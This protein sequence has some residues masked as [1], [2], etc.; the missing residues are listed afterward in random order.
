VE[1]YTLEY[2]GADS[3][4]VAVDLAETGVSTIR[5]TA[6]HPVSKVRIAS[7]TLPMR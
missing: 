1:P 3:A 6:A 2:A 7:R 5:V 4:L